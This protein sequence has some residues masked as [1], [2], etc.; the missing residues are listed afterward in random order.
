MSGI[1]RRDRL[2]LF[3]RALIAAVCALL[4]ILICA[5]AGADAAD[6]TRRVACAGCAR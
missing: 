4:C 3:P 6:A 5:A 2:S 1:G